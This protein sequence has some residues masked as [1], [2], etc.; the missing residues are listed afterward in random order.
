MTAITG[1]VLGGVSL[2]GGRGTVAR[3]LIGTIFL[4]LLVAGLVRTGI[5]GAVTS[6]AQGL[7]LLIAVAFDMKWAKHKTRAIQKIY[8]NPTLVEFPPMPA[9][10]RDAAPPYAEN[11]GLL[12][13]EAIG[14]EQV[15]GPE[16]VILDCED[17][18]YTGVRDG[19]ILRFSGPNHEK[20]EIFARVGGTPLGMAF[21][22]AGNLIFCNPGMGL[23]GVTPD[24]QVFK[25]TDQTPR[26]WFRLNDDSRLRY[27]N[28]LD[29]APDGRIYFSDS[30]T[31][32]EGGNWIFD[33]IEGRGNGRILCYDPK[34]GKTRTVLKDCVLPN[35]VCVSHDGQSVLWCCTWFCAVYRLWIAG[36]KSGQVEVFASNLPGLV[37]N[38]NRASD[39]G[40]WVAIV[41]LRTP[42]SDLAYE[43]PGFRLRMAKQLPVDEWLYPGFNNGCVIKLD[44]QGRVTGSLW[45]P[46]GAKHPAVTS[47][48]EHKGWLYL[49]GLENNRIGRIRLPDADPNWV[50]LNS[51]WG[52]SG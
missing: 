14:L 44:A 16:D 17:N 23:Y 37:D 41:A 34:T 51:Y 3:G 43:M 8:V 25:L 18:L 15:E 9:I 12:H 24:R 46:S 42:V 21:D 6:M 5:S 49:G 33:C 1:A 11:D 10:A 29:I 4:F 47:M 35:G 27:A 45:D 7:V 22:R 19:F 28:D 38:I 40:Y 39:G 48:R 13:A 50:G 31:R 32:Y 20:R 30:T 2:S 26:S 52:A 36:S